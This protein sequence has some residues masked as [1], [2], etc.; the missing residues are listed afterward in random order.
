MLAMCGRFTQRAKKID[1]ATLFDV[2]YLGPFIA[3]RYNVAPTQPALVVR[4]DLQAIREVLPM[5]HQGWSRTGPRIS[6][7]ATR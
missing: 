7:S 4:I 2:E 6:P 1:V 5:R 3:P